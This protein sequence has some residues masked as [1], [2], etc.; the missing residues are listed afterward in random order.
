MRA[1]RSV[2]FSDEGRMLAWW[3]LVRLRVDINRIGLVLVHL[4]VAMSFFL[5]ME[6]VNKALLLG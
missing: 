1:R 2:K 4:I 3:L 6:L 5:S